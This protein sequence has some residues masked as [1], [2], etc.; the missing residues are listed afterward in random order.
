MKEWQTYSFK[1]LAKME[2]FLEEYRVPAGWTWRVE[3]SWAI[4]K[5]IYILIHQL[6]TR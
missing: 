6:D 4:D 1:E 2:K 3:A 5:T